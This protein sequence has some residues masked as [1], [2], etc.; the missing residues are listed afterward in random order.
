MAYLHC[1]IPIQFPIL[2]SVPMHSNR[3]GQHQNRNGKGMSTET[4]LESCNVNKPLCVL[5]FHSSCPAMHGMPIATETSALR[6]MQMKQ[7]FFVP[8]D[9]VV[10]EVNNSTVIPI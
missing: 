1:P 6:R 9:L 7:N 5:V 8:R 10:S 2:I 3:R 4:I